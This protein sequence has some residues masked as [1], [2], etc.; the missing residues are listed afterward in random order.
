[1][2]VEANVPIC[3]NTDAHSLSEFDM[4]PYG[5]LTARRGWAKKTDIL[6]ARP[7]EA[8]EK[9]LAERKSQSTW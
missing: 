1:M 3:I 6:N 2:A 5:V 8:I 7:L 4:M 9:W